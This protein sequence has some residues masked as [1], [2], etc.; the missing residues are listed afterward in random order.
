MNLTEYRSLVFDCDGVILDSNKVKTQAFYNTALPYGKGAAQELVLYHVANGGISRYKKFEYFLKHIVRNGFA[1]HE[2]DSLL[3]KYAIEVNSGLMTCAVAEGLDQLRHQTS[4]AAWFIVSGGDQDELQKLF[5]M[6]GLD[7]F[8]GGIYGSPESKE[9]I[10]RRL[11]NNK[12]ITSPS[13]FF[14]DSRYDH[15]ASD[16]VITS[17]TFVSNWTE[18]TDWRQYCSRNQLPAITKLSDLLESY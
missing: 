11:V 5:E 7:Y 14:G 16:G 18:F 12:I 2:L 9:N 3:E 17:F 10:L 13:M 15:I 6:R 4:S 8:D 1:E